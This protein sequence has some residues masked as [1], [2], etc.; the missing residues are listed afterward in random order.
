LSFNGTQGFEAWTEY[1]RTGY[2]D[3]I[4]ASAASNLE[5][6]ELPKRIIY[7][8]TEAT[9]NQNYPGLKEIDV[10]VWWDVKD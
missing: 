2:P 5:A 8:N 1:R 7:P 4:Q 9:R 6:G 10:P 3:F